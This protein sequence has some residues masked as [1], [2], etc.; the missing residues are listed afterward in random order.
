MRHHS[1]AEEQQSKAHTSVIESDSVALQTPGMTSREP[2]QLE[3]DDKY[4][5]AEQAP[6]GVRKDMHISSEARDLQPT[7]AVTADATSDITGGKT[8]QARFE[9]DE[10]DIAGSENPYMP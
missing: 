1:S 8:K 5:T 10:L 9:V 3:A 4:V 2:F 6:A 7:N